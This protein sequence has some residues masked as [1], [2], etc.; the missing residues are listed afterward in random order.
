MSCIILAV[1]LVVSGAGPAQAGARQLLYYNHAWG[2]LD[3]ATADAVEHSRYLKDF[4]D[5]EVRTTTG[6]DGKVW[7]GRYLR[8]RETYMEIFG[9][10]DVPG[11]DGE[12]GSAGLGLSTEHDGDIEK[13]KARLL[14]AGEKP[15]DFLQTRD[16]GDGK[17]VPWFDS[18]FLIEEYERFGAWAMEYRD[19]YMDDPRS[20]VGPA[21]FP[22]D[23]TRQRYLPDVYEDKMMRDVTLVRLAV[24]ASDLADTVPLLRAGG[25]SLRTEPGS[26]VATRGGTTMR[27]D[28]A[29]PTRI[30]L[31]RVEFALNRPVARHVEELGTSTLVV[32]PGKRAVWTF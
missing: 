10:G 15:I 7:T 13:L 26:V 6:A 3:R 17:P 32:G 29:P 21:R 22:G 23:V 14:A 4:A 5:L 8:G 19:E 12:P 18:L 25:F 9:P 24:T 30:G 31:K 16:F 27:F 11:K 20:K 2:T 1:V 28:E